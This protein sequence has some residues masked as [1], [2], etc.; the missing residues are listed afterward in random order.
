MRYLLGA[1][2]VALPVAVQA[3]EAMK[4]GIPDDFLRSS[5][6]ECVSN[7]GTAAAHSY[8]FCLGMCGCMAG[9]IGRHWDMDEANARV[10]R[11]R[12]DPAD[13]EVAGEMTRLAQYCVERV[14]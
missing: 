10:Q 2:I 1:L 3:Q 9:E 13:A 6:D 7:C 5:F 4:E 11:L 12:S 14:R 8:S